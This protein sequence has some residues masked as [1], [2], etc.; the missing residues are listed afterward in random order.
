MPVWATVLTNAVIV[1]T[2]TFVA[3]TARIAILI[4]LTN[5]IS[6]RSQTYSLAAVADIPRHLFQMLIARF[7]V[8][9]KPKVLE[10]VGVRRR[11]TY[12]IQ[13]GLKSRSRA[14]TNSRKP[15]AI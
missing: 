3:V 7:P 8:H 2:M 9:K 6:F 15:D 11:I 1:V 13:T 4:M 5:V 12:N 14:P 10:F